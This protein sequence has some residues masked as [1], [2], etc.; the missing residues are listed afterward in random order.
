MTRK[1]IR[2]L[3]VATCLLGLLLFATAIGE[4]VEAAQHHVCADNPY[5]P[6]CHL[7]Q[8]VAGF[9]NL[10]QTFAKLE[11]LGSALIPAEPAFRS[12][13]RIS[14]LSTRAPPSA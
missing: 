9:V 10:S 12:L 3:V 7:D 11:R 5:C 2:S 4:A 1:V 6:T 8:Q 14:L 13:L